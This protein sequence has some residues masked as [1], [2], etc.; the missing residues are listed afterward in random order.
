M[1]LDECVPQALRRHIAYHEVVAAA[2]AG[3]SGFKNGALLK[4]VG[5]AEFDVL[6]T[7]DRT[8]QYEQNLSGRTLSVVPIG[9]RL[10]HHQAACSKDCR[11]SGCRNAR[12]VYASGLRGVCSTG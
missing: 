8:L 3:L 10:A 12:I 5:E 7:G 6:V 11:R 1:L 2:Y 9:E 4:A